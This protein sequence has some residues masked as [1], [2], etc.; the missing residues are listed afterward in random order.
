MRLRSTRASACTS[1]RSGLTCRSRP[2]K[3]IRTEISAKFR[4][5]GSRAELAG[6]GLRTLAWWTDDAGDFALSLAELAGPQDGRFRRVL[7]RFG[8]SR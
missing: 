6:A 5:P 3:Q 2:A 8:D 4:R 1:P 7:A